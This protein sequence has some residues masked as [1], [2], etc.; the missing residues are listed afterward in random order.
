MQNAVEEQRNGIGT[1]IY[2]II[3]HE[4]KRVVKYFWK[5]YRFISDQELCS[6][7]S[8][9][10]K[11]DPFEEVMEAYREVKVA[12]LMEIKGPSGSKMKVKDVHRVLKA[13][14]PDIGHTSSPHAHSI[15][16][17][18]DPLLSNIMKRFGNM[19]PPSRSEVLW[20]EHTEAFKKQMEL[21]TMRRSAMME[22]QMH[23][24]DSNGSNVSEINTAVRYCTLSVIIHSMRNL[25][26]LDIF[27]GCDA[28]CKIFFEG[29]QNLFLT[30]VRRGQREEE[31]TWD[32]SLSD[33]FFWDLPMDPEHL[34]PN[35]RVVVMVMDKDQLSKDDLVGCVT[36]SLRE[37]G[38]TGT[39]H[40][41]KRI[42]GPPNRREFF[43]HK[44]T[45]GEVKLSV[46]LRPKPFSPEREH[47]GK[48][49][50]DIL[51]QSSGNATVHASSA[52]S[53]TS[54]FVYL[55]KQQQ[56]GFT[57]PP[58]SV[59]SESSEGQASVLAR[60]QPKMPMP[61]A[62]PFYQPPE[63]A[64]EP[65]GSSLFVTLGAQ[66]QYGGTSERN[67]AGP[68]SDHR[69]DLRSWLG[70]GSPVSLTSAAREA[71]PPP[72]PRIPASS[73]RIRADTV[74]PTPPPQAATRQRTAP[75]DHLPTAPVVLQRKQHT[76]SEF[77]WPCSL[78]HRTFQEQDP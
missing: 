67:G 63:T 7:L 10:V 21:E 76:S 42:A 16:L 62:S 25:P 35:R 40:G 15:D 49:A 70:C 33:N 65:T 73:A 24:N 69:Q 44:H 28:F 32:P 53:L 13:F 55:E 9:H 3:T 1:E 75:P 29:S 27:R 54:A 2:R 46:A 57:V 37:L 31:W 5:G 50:S 43:W 23:G 36:V 30:E 17:F 11:D 58:A 18:L 48:V 60:M 19:D 12:A 78:D 8:N 4:C 39:F 71:S 59:L 52:A 47:N 38:D 22:L 26:S 20:Q 64:S 41:W 68:A 56:P 14:I 61:A 72:N 45:N 77:L 74:E 51:H 34:L 66:H 6:L